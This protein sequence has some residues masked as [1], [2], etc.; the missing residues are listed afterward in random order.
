MHSYRFL[1]LFLAAACCIPWIAYGAESYTLERLLSMTREHNRALMAGRD[2]LTAARAGIVAARAFPNPEL[3]YVSGTVRARV[4]GPLEGGTRGVWLSQRLEYPSQRQARAEAASA[5]ADAARADLRGLAGDVFGLVRLRF[6]EVLRREA[7]LHAAREDLALM[8]QIRKRVEVKVSTGE[9]PRYELIKAEAETLNAQKAAQ[10]A[11]LRTRQAKAVLR[12][13][14][15]AP[16]ADGFVLDGQLERTIPV[17][18]LEELRTELVQRNPELLRLRA[19]Q[20]QAQSQLDFERSQRLPS[21]TLKAGT[22]QDPEVRS[23]RIGVVLSVPVFDRRTGPVDAAAAN[24]SRARHELENREFVLFQMLEAAYRQYEIAATQA[25][26]LESGIV[27]QA[28][29]ALRIAEA[30]YRF[31]ERGILDYLDAQRVF[32]AARSDLIAARFDLQVATIEIERL[33][34]AFDDISS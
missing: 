23:G 1:R 24:L 30:A 11:E 13:A 34:A 26:A 2:A 17:L 16:L 14:V 5:A 15:G 27:R 3:E 29:E 7:E 20:V 8:E 4:P 21:L 22:D 18:T 12:Q 31:G 32:R 19:L 33:R 9:A 10:S 28:G 6:Y 25:A